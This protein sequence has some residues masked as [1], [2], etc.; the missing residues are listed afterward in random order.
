VRAVRIQNPS[1]AAIGTMLFALR[2]RTVGYRDG[3]FERW[4]PIK[5]RQATP[6]SCRRPWRFAS[7]ER[8]WNRYGACQHSAAG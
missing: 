7:T 4:M 2:Q 8:F 3:I 6:T 5:G 1:I